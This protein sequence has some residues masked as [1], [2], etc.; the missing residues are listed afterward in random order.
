[1]W[2]KTRKN[3]YRERAPASG[4]RGFWCWM[5]GLVGVFVV[6]RVSVVYGQWLRILQGPDQDVLTAIAVYDTAVIV[7]GNSDSWGTQQEW[8][9]GAL[10]QQSGRTMWFYR[11]GAS[12]RDDLYDV[13]VLPN[14]YVLFSGETDAG[15]SSEVQVA[16]FDWQGNFYW[17]QRLPISYSWD[18]WHMYVQ[19]WD[20]TTFL[21]W[22]DVYGRLFWRIGAWDSYYFL[23]DVN[24]NITYHA[25]HGGQASSEGAH[26]FHWVRTTGTRYLLQWVFGLGLG[27][28]DFMLSEVSANGTSLWTK[29]YGTGALEVP[30]KMFVYAQHILLIGW[31]NAGP[32]GGDDLLVL[33]V[34]RTN[35]TL[36]QSTAW[37]TPLDERVVQGVQL[38]D[39][40]IVLAGWIE[41]ASQGRDGLLVRMDSMG[42]VLW[43]YR[44]GDLGDE[45]ILDVAY[46][47]GWLY[48]AGWTTS[49]GALNQDGW[50]MKVDTQ[51]VMPCNSFPV[52]LVAN[53]YPVVEQAHNLVHR[54]VPY[55]KASGPMPF[56]I[57]PDTP[58]ACVVLSFSDVRLEGSWAESGEV[59]LRW[60]V[61]LPEGADW[62]RIDRRTP[63]T[64]YQT[65]YEV[66]DVLPGIYEG[67]WT[68]MTVPH[69]ASVLV[70]RASASTPQG[71]LHSREV[72]L[73]AP[74]GLQPVWRIFLGDAQYTMRLPVSST[75]DVQIVLVNAVGQVIAPL[76]WEPGYI[77][78]PDQPAGIY[79]LQVVSASSYVY[80]TRVILHGSSRW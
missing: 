54:S 77:V 72:V 71:T 70:Y 59:L 73:V 49:W 23:V 31:T 48:T 19:P 18:V 57:N 47:Q 8:W 25:I 65:V 15:F 24:G 36:L 32:A 63:Q 41:T 67:M 52:T 34:D 21:V 30:W 22:G 5:V 3:T 2:G 1:M 6:L 17:R 35:G 55:L 4:F 43:A 56:P 13:A 9:V 60:E 64:P 33:R 29:T 7:G 27:S 20:A 10:S 61:A 51:G 58:Y 45:E 26:D 11:L 38:P 16:L 39:G 46:D 62:F 50:V 78:F 79:N 37:G 75:M 28:S 14:G 66:L 80:T 74:A 42:N 76:Y 53:P 68:D 12:F 69:E 40:S 44:Y